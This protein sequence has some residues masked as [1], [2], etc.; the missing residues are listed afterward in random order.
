MRAAEARHARA[1]GQVFTMIDL[2]RSSTIF[3]PC[4]RSLWIGFSCIVCLVSS[5]IASELQSKASSFFDTIVRDGDTILATISRNAEN[6]E[7]WYELSDGDSPHLVQPSQQFVF[8][9]RV[10]I[11]FF[12]HMTSFTATARFM[13]PPGGLLFETK[14]RMSSTSDKFVAETYFIQAH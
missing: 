1:P 6:S 14:Y 2:Q 7:G 10:S 12:T 9:D 5:S 3:A 4:M 11:Q 13:L 8:H